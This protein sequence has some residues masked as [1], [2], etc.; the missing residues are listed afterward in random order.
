MR[1]IAILRGIN[2][3]GH[4]KIL[5]K[6]FKEQLKE[7]GFTDIITY[8]QSGNVIFSSDEPY[9]LALGKTI[10]DFIAEEY[11]YDV[12]VIVRTVEEW[13]EVIA[14]NPLIP[15]GDYDINRYLVILLDKEP[16]PKSVKDLNQLDF[17][18]DKFVVVGKNIYLYSAGPVH[19]SKLTINMFEKKLGVVASARNWKTVLR[20]KEL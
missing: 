8:I 7:L 1:Y 20:I 9:C 17:S 10:K 19:K 14:N 3:G 2:V 5:M 16:D 13:Q 18:P 15:D 4:R 11:V 12:P 6:V